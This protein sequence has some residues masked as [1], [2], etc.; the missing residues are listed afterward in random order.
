MCLTWVLVQGVKFLPPG[1]HLFTITPNSSTSALG[2]IR[3]G[4]FH[5]TTPQQILLRTWSADAEALVDSQTRRTAGR[6]APEPPVVVSPA[7]LQTM[8]PHLAPYPLDAWDEWKSLTNHVDE[9]VVGLVVGFDARGDAHVDSMSEGPEPTEGPS[10][11]PHLTFPEVTLTRSAPPDASGPLLTRYTIDKS[12]L[13]DSLARDHLQGLRLRLVGLLQLAFVLFVRV[14][15]P[16]AMD[17]Y[18]KLLVAL[19]Y[20]EELA[21]GRSPLQDGPSVATSQDFYLE[22]VRALVAQMGHL[23]KEFFL[24][25]APAEEDWWLK[26]VQTLGRTLDAAGRD[27]P[28]TTSDPR[29]KA[30]AKLTALVGERFG[31]PVAVL[32]LDAS[33]A[34]EEDEED[35]EDRP[36]V[37]DL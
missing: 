9:W 30:W 37:V 16:A 4:F 36:V 14:Q 17:F 6:P 5:F 26:A 2:G 7:H 11:G 21:A 18:R 15:N 8:D 13:V 20:S 32:K 1:M 28:P 19:S 35:E 3:Q 10:S 23:R 27:V 34:D 29:R 25:D 33:T 12:F 31:W 22:L 24:Q